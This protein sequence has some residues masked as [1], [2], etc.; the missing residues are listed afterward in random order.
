VCDRIEESVADEFW[1]LPK[2]REMLSLIS[3]SWGVLQSHPQT[4][5]RYAEMNRLRAP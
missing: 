4:P 1:T 5:A 2:Y 3:S